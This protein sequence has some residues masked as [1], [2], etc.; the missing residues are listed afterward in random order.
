MIIPSFVAAYTGKSTSDVKLNPFETTPLP[1]W[2]LNYTGLTNIPFFE[3]KFTSFRLNHAYT[4]NF[5][6]NQFNS[7]LKYEGPEDYFLPT[8]IDTLS[9]NFYA[10]YYIPQVIITERFA[11]LAGVDFALKN[12]FT[13]NVNYNKSRTLGMSLLDYQ[14]SESN[15]TSFT[16]GAGYQ[17]SNFKLPFKLF[18]KT[19]ELEND[20]YFRLDYSFQDDIVTNYKLDQNTSLPT[21]GAKTISI[22]PTVDYTLNDRINLQLYL[23]RRRSEPKTR[24]SYP[25]SNTRGGMKLSYT[26]N[27]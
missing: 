19:R 7:N 20:L 24:S 8:A 3:D 17:T 1:N 12:G 15:S 27:R 5:S 6:I 21:R 25:V 16:V 11:P 2:S 18:G 4:S 14:L 26:F 22:Y 9:N 13:A 10:F 23:D